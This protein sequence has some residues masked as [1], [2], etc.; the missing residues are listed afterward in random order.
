[1]N[2]PRRNQETWDQKRRDRR[3]GHIRITVGDVIEHVQPEERVADLE[4]D[5]CHH[6]RPKRRL[7]VG[8]KREPEERDREEPHQTEGQQETSFGT[9][10]SA[11]SDAVA[12]VRPC[13]QGSEDHKHDDGADDKVQI[14]QVGVDVARGVEVVSIGSA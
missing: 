14:S 12:S 1:M 11:V 8:G 9:A 10:P 6:G 3:R 2:T 4:D 5:A 7:P 13:L